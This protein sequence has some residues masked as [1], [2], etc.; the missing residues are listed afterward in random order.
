MSQE[1][2]QHERLEWH[3]GQSGRSELIV[4]VSVV[5]VAFAVF[6]FFL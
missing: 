1:Q 5:L 4:S 2:Y 6:S 3:D